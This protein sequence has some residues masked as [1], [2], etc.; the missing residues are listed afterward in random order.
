MNYV[1]FI[2]K[3][4]LGLMKTRRNPVSRLLS[5]ASFVILGTMVFTACDKKNEDKNNSKT[6]YSISGNASTSQVVPSVSG[7]GTAAITGTYNSGNGQMITTTTW[8]DLSGVPI[9]GGFYTGA[10]GT[11]GSLI[12]DLWSLGTGLATSGTFSDT[13]TLTSE[14]ATALKGGNIYYSLATAANPNGEVRGQ[15]TATPQ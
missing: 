4:K 10:A 11:N 15:L 6:M 5:I 3:Q 12:G 14:Q 1:T 2:V 13:T 8:T 7:T 9:S